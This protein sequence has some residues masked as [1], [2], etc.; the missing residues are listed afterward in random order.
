[1]GQV[2]RFV[3]KFKGAELSPA[4]SK[5]FGEPSC[6]MAGASLWAH[7]ALLCFGEGVLV[8]SGVGKET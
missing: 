5:G 2:R 4:R 7:F 6:G 3:V 1:M 8:Y